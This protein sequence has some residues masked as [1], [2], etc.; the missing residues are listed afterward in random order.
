MK[1][2]SRDIF[3]AI[4]EIAAI[5]G[6][7]KIPRL[8]TALE[9][10]VFGKVMNYCYNPFVTF[11][12][13]KLPEAT[14]GTS[15]FD[16]TT[17]TLLDKLAAREWTGNQAKEMITQ[18]LSQLCEASGQLLRRIIL[19]DMRA[20]FTANSVNKAKPGHLP[21]FDVMLAHK[22]EPKRIKDKKV[23]VETK[24]DGVR[25]LS[26]AHPG[27]KP[28]F[29]S[30]TGKEFSGFDH[31]SDQLMAMIVRNATIHSLWQR[32]GIIFD[33]E[34]MA[35]DG[36]FNSIT[37]DVHATK[38]EKSGLANFFLFEVLPYDVLAKGIDSTPYE[39]RRQRLEG[40]YQLRTEGEANIV[41]AP[42]YIAETD[43]DIR[44]LFEKELER[45]GE[46]VIVK[47]L[48]G[49]YECKRSYSW[50]KVKDENSA[51]LLVTGLF[52]GEGKYKGKLGGLICDFNG[53]E[54]RVG[55]GFSDKQREELFNLDLVRNRM[56]EVEYHETTPDGSLRHPRFVKFRDDKPV[57]DGVGV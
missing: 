36:K 34:L 10:E 23:R 37:G 11:G 24:F 13:K 9:C 57:E 33:G 50:L 16:L 35:A 51:D 14:C 8:A 29:F 48:D 19:K 15:E 49:P 22:Y 32:F 52:E 1:M 25:C 40:F 27:A 55:G 31:L 41:L 18:Q 56:I 21:A 30:R 39:R 46:G 43:E 20:G 2:T 38:R 28:R 53:V 17:W 54:V 45:G 6:K 7:A 4:E 12:I 47:P 42:S 26:I 3:Q 5:S 44:R